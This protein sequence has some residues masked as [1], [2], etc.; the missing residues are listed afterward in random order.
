[1]TAFEVRANLRAVDGF[2]L[3]IRLA[4]LAGLAKLHRR[5]AKVVEAVGSTLARGLPR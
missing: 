4:G 5:L 1:M 3:G 2:E